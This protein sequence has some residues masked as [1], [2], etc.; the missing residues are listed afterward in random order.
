MHMLIQI[1]SYSN[2]YLSSKQSLSLSH[3]YILP[4]RIYVQPTALKHSI[5]P[6]LIRIV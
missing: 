1:S 2:E 5:T 3:N 6:L 4:S